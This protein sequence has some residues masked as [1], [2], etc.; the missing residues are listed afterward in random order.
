MCGYPVDERVTKHPGEGTHEIFDLHRAPARS[1]VQRTHRLT[2]ILKC[3][4]RM[5]RAALL[6]VRAGIEPF[7]IQRADSRRREH[8]FLFRLAPR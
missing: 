6:L 8:G 5:A 3:R 7:A 1:F 2:Y 4:A